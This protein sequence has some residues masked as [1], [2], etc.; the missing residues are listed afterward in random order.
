MPVE[1]DQTGSAPLHVSLVAIPEAGISTLT[2]MFDVMS[3]FA[4]LPTPG[5]APDQAPPFRV[6][7]VGLET[8]PLQ[9][10]SRVPITVQRSIAELATTDIVI[11]PSVVV[12]PGGWAKGRHPEL[13]EWLRAM[14]R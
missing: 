9:L 13:V 5:R 14:H 7:I 2:G 12:G 4:I 10:A 3:A 8:G 11:V 1:P 6:E